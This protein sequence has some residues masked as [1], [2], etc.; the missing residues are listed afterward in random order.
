M[1]VFRHTSFLTN[2]ATIRTQNTKYTSLILTLFKNAK[3][4]H[5]IEYKTASHEYKNMVILVTTTWC[6]NIKQNTRAQTR[7][8]KTHF[9]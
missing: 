3:A 2:K 9:T 1:V 4:F 5:M 7:W 8:T 6:Q